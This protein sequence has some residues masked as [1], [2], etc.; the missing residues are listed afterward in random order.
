MCIG[1]GIKWT[2]V[3]KFLNEK[4]LAVEGRN[5]AVGEGGLTLRDKLLL[6][7]SILAFLSLPV[8]P[9]RNPTSSS[10]ISLFQS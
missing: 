1:A 2:D 8:V 9:L 7:K 5:F 6:F 4:G 3:S 10:T